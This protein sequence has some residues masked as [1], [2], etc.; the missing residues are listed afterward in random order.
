MTIFRPMDEGGFG[1]HD[2]NPTIHVPLNSILQYH[3]NVL[4]STLKV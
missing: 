3:L 4:N 1:V 2:M